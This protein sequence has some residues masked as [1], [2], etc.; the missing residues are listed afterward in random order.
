MIYQSLFPSPL[1]LDTLT[2][3]PDDLPQIS[4]LLSTCS[5]VYEEA[6]PIMYR[7]VGIEPDVEADY[8]LAYRYFGM[9]ND[10][11]V[12]MQLHTMPLSLERAKIWLGLLPAL[13]T[14]K[15]ITTVYIK[16]RNA[17]TPRRRAIVALLARIVAAA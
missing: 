15:L 2:D 4:A 16:R 17:K 13:K 10:A 8:H 5:Q 9:V 7:N 3:D 12:E 6:A 1:F 14:C 11:T